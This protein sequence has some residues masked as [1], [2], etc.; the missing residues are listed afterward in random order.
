MIIVVIVISIESI[1]DRGGGGFLKANNKEF[2][3]MRDLLCWRDCGFVI[4]SRGRW[5]KCG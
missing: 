4:R 3:C 2:E 5:G 1:D